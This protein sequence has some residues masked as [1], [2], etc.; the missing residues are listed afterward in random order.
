MKLYQSALKDYR[1]FFFLEIHNLLLNNP[2]I[3]AKVKI[4]IQLSK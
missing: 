4:V 3:N 2:K 1:L